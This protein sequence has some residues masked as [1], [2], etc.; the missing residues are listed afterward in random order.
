MG[1]DLQAFSLHKATKKEALEFLRQTAEKRESITSVKA[2]KML[3]DIFDPDV[4]RRGQPTKNPDVILA[5]KAGEIRAIFQYIP[6]PNKKR[7]ETWKDLLLKIAGVSTNTLLREI[8]GPA[9]VFY[10]T[11]YLTASFKLWAMGGIKLRIR[12][13]ITPEQVEAAFMEWV[14]FNTVTPEQAKDLLT[15]LV[16]LQKITQE[17][18]EKMSEYSKNIYNKKYP[19]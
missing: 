10:I 2:I 16:S 13:D 17:T 4:D 19:K 9:K 14:L 18:A 15:E 1:F 12:K 5:M 3:A 7:G 11:S 8:S 6:I